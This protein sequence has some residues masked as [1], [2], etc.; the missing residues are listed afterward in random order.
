M[1]EGMA[2]RL[3]TRICFLLAGTALAITGGWLCLHGLLGSEPLPSICWRE[4]AI[5]IGV[6]ILGCFFV[7]HGKRQRENWSHNGLP[8]ATSG[9]FPERRRST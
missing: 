2:I 5:G 9:A 6:F 3:V 8:G 1:N 4:V 7:W